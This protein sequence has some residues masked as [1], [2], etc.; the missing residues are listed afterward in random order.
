M[1][2]GSSSDQAAA[3]HPRVTPKGYRRRGWANRKLGMRN[4]RPAVHAALRGEHGMLPRPRGGDLSPLDL[5]TGAVGAAKD[6]GGVA[7][8]DEDLPALNAV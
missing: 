4:I 5:K 6:G 8:G 1:L 3:A 2:R 7:A